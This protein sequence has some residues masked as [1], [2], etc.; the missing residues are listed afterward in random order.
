MQIF[1]NELPESKHVLSLRFLFTITT[2]K[3][4]LLEGSP[5]CMFVIRLSALPV[6]AVCFLLDAQVIVQRIMKQANYIETQ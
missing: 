5:R 6:N 4:L 1:K 2:N 3:D